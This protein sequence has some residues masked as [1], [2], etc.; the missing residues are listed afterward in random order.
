MKEDAPHRHSPRLQ[1]VGDDAL[2]VVVGNVEMNFFARDED[3]IRPAMSSIASWY[4]P[5]NEIP[6]GLGQLIHVP[7]WRCHSG[8]NE[9]PC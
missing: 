2:V 5:G 8:G 7:R 6:S 9:K 1:E 4:L 3:S